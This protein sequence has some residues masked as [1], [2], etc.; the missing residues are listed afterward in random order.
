MSAEGRMHQKEV[1]LHNR[2]RDACGNRGVG[3]AILGTRQ[4]KIQRKRF[5][6]ILGEPD[7]KPHVR[8]R[9]RKRL[10]V[11]LYSITLKGYFPSF[12][13]HLW[14]CFLHIFLLYRVQQ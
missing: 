10:A 3:R 7:A 12:L 11:A 14:V 13:E 5:C 2:N 4:R 8:R 6:A 1:L 9:Q